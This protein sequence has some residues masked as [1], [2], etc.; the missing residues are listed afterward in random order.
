MLPAVIFDWFQP[1]TKGYLDENKKKTVIHFVGRER[2]KL[3][4]REGQG[5]N[6]PKKAPLNQCFTNKPIASN[7]KPPKCLPLRCAISR[8]KVRYHALKCSFDGGS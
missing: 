2:H 3:K 7:L 6:G 5:S 1:F 8:R 4:C